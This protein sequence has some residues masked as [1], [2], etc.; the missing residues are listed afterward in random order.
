[1]SGEGLDRAIRRGAPLVEITVLFKNGIDYQDATCRMNEL[2]DELELNPGNWYND[3]A[4]RVG[5]ATKE[6]L[7]SLFGWSLIRVPLERYDETNK[8]WTTWENVYRWQ[9]TGPPKRYPPEVAQLIQSLGF[10][11]PGAD[12]DGQWYE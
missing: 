1:M 5:A 8:V 6:A 7:E 3:P 10:S 12:D 2:S 4:L 11:Q 9:E